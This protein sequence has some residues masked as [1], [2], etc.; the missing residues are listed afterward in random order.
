MEVEEELSLFFSLK[1]S[2]RVGIISALADTLSLFFSLKPETEA[3]DA[4]K[5]DA[6]LYAFTLLFIET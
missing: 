2:N 6:F 3:F 5:L 1:L 4:P